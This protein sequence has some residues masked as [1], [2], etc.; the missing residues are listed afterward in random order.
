VL[1]TH[2]AVANVAVVGLPD[3]EWGEV[4]AA[5]IQARPGTTP[6][7]AELEAFRRRH[8]ASHK[9][10]RVWRFFSYFP[11]TSSGKLQKFILCEQALR[12]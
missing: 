5:F 1:F 11:Q 8:P 4:V 12:R 6:D 10:T 2:P 9:V 7:G 3:P